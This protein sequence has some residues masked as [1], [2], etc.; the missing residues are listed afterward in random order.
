LVY[1][2][3]PW[4]SA[5]PA[6]APVTEAAASPIVVTAKRAQVVRAAMPAERRIAV[7]P[8][9]PRPRFVLAAVEPKL[10]PLTLMPMRLPRLPR[11]RL[12]TLAAAAPEPAVLRVSTALTRTFVIHASSDAAA[13]D[14]VRAAI[15]EAIARTGDADTRIRLESVEQMLGGAY[16]ATIVQDQNQGG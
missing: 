6:A 1:A 12:L 9:P 3:R 11:L 16:V 4:A 7:A 10:A 13:R 2:P 8:P 14:Q 5:A 15:E